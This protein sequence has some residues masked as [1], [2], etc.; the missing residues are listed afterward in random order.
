MPEKLL[1]E[2]VAGQVRQAFAQLQ[3]PVQVLY[4][5]AKVGCDY[6]DDTRQLLEEVT[7]LSDQLSLSVHDLDDDAALAAQYKI[8][9]APGIVLAAR[10]GDQVVD[11][12]VHYAGIPAGHEF[13][14]LIQD[15][16]L[17]SGRDSGLN[18]KTR[19]FLKQLKQ[20]VHLQV[21]VTPT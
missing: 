19:S 4:F 17:V 21:F 7:E 3:N 10:D 13:A 2:S 8:D 6:C 9:K 14:S 18:P 11:Y 5:G 1:N 16:I 12:G 15:L 20:P